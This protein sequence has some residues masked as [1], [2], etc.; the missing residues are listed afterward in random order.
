MEDEGDPFS[1]QTVDSSPQSWGLDRIDQ[2]T[3]PLD[4]KFYYPSSA[5]QGVNI[6][7]IDTGI[8]DTHANFNG[9]ASLDFDAIGGST[10]YADDCAGHGTHVAGTA[11]GLYTGVA[12]KANIHSVRVLDCSGSGYTSQIVAG[13]NWVAQNHVKPAVAN[14]SL[15]GWKSPTE[16]AAVSKAIA[17]GVTFVVSAGNSGDYG[18]YYGNACNFSPARVPGAITV[19]ATDDTDMRAD[20]S[21]FGSCLDVFAPGVN[22]S[23]SIMSSDTSYQ[24]GWDGTSMAAP[25]VTG[26]A[27]LFLAANPT[28]KPK[29]VTKYI[30]DNALLNTVDDVQ[31]SP[32][33]LLHIRN[34]VPVTGPI[35]VSPVKYLTVTDNTPTFTWKP[36]TDAN[37]YTLHLY[38]AASNP[39]GNFEDIE[40]TQYTQIDALSDGIYRWAVSAQD[41]IHVYDTFSQQWFFAIDTTGPNAPVQTFPTV[42]ATTTGIPTFK[43]STVSGAK[44]YRFAYDEDSVAAPY[45]FISTSLTKPQYLPVNLPFNKNIFWSVQAADSLGNWGPWSAPRQLWVDPRIPAAPKLLSPQNNKVLSDNTPTLSWNNV[46]YAEQYQIEVARDPK[47]LIVINNPDLLLSGPSYDSGALDEWKFYWH[48]RAINADH[49]VGPYSTAFAFTIDMTPPGNPALLSPAYGAS[50]TGNPTFT[51]SAPATAKT[52]KFQ[53]ASNDTFTSPVSSGILTKTSFKPAIAIPEGDW[54]WRVFAYDAYGNESDY[55]M[56]RLIHILPATP[57]KVVLSAPSTGFFTDDASIHLVW[58]PVDY[59]KKYRVQ[60]DNLA[61]FSSPEYDQ[62]TG[63]GETTRDVATSLLLPGKWYWRVQGIPSLGKAGLWSLSRYFTISS[64]FSANFSS[65]NDVNWFTQ[66]YGASWILDTANGYYFN[67]GIEDGWETTS[68]AYNNSLSDYT[69][70]ARLKM[71]EGTAGSEYGYYGLL[72]RSKPYG[73]WYLTEYTDGYSFDIYQS[74]GWDMGCFEVYSNKSFKSTL[75]GGFCDPIIKGNDWNT[76]KV[77]ANGSRLKFYVND[78]LLWQGVNTVY[79]TGLVGVFNWSGMTC[80]D[81]DGDGY[82]DYLYGVPGRMYIDSFS[83]NAPENLITSASDVLIPNPEYGVAPKSEKEYTIP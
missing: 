15:G 33:R 26:V 56:P 82:C 40:D 1:I 21:N 17:K 81:D 9:R 7:I 48:V 72:V 50:S 37:T 10:P 47:F 11:A 73:G 74:N 66:Y 20:F 78:I 31:G 43:W 14:M 25:H 30:L 18:S 4:T 19:G 23:S 36:L 24:G 80:P 51:W 59:A 79:K 76:L 2:D 77:S 28:A 5:G 52:Y 16:D 83:I 27:A 46:L 65:S 44:T 67:N 29:D 39:I 6:Y 54:Y 38:D 35:L 57:A 62:E 58:L 75:L 70:E 61:T 34:I 12:R 49:Q 32:N 13:I 3:L 53:Y 42:D 22:I 69:V 8:R 71:D 64:T 55:N 41:S 60:I 45:E 63:I 68:I